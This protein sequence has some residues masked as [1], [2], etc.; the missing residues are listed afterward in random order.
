MQRA[1]HA[2]VSPT[3]ATP[4]RRLTNRTRF[5]TNAAR[6]NLTVDASGGLQ[7]IRMLQEAGHS[8]TEVNGDVILM[9]WPVNRSTKEKHL[10]KCSTSVH[11]LV[12]RASPL[13]RSC[14]WA[15]AVRFSLTSHCR[16]LGTVSRTVLLTTRVAC[17]RPVKTERRLRPVMSGGLSDGIRLPESM[18]KS[19][20]FR[21]VLLGLVCPIVVDLLFRGGHFFVKAWICCPGHRGKHT[22]SSQD[23]GN[24]PITGQARTGLGK[25]EITAGL[26]I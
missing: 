20:Q 17:V 16:T 13:K 2:R 11:S 4:P 1:P 10:T 21:S 5:R 18:Q 9:P 19:R 23:T 6:W 3:P 26:D 15:F 7:T 22:Q 14:P 8:L 25:K 12:Q 24:H